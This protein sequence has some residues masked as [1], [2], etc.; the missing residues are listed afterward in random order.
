VT[1]VTLTRYRNPSVASAIRTARSRVVVG[2]VSST[3][4][5]PYALAIFEMGMVSSS[6]MSGI[7][8]P[9]QKSH[10]PSISPHR[11]LVSP[12]TYSEYDAAKR[13]FEVRCSVRRS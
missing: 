3:R 5:T 12:P 13:M 11:A 8:S 10:S 4:S 9:V 6:G 1:P 7:S 2:V